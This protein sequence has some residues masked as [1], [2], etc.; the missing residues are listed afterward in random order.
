MHYTKQKSFKF[1]SFNFC[2]VPFE[3]HDKSCARINSLN[4]R[5]NEP[6][7]IFDPELRYQQ[8]QPKG[9]GFSPVSITQK[10]DNLFNFICKKINEAV[11]GFIGLKFFLRRT[12]GGCEFGIC[13]DL[14]L[15][16]SE[17]LKRL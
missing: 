2:F 13:L 12:L 8:R 17:L 6:E 16:D 9:S 15:K 3:L 11:G 1:C 5:E 7:Y 10:I 14:N 4:D